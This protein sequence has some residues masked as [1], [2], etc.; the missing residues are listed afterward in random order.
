MPRKVRSGEHR[1]QYC[2]NPD[3]GIRS[4]PHVAIVD[5]EGHVRW[6][7]VG[8]KAIEDRV[9]ELLMAMGVKPP[10]RATV[11]LATAIV[12]SGDP[13]AERVR[14]P[15]DP[16]AM[17]RFTLYHGP[18]ITLGSL[19]TQPSNSLINQSFHAKER[20]EPLNGD[21]FGIAWYAPEHSEPAVFR[22]ITP[23]WNNTNLQSLARVVKSK[24]ILAH[25]RAATQVSASSEANCHPFTH[26]PYAFM[27]NGDIGGFGRVRRP[28]LSQLSDRS[29][30]AIK[31]TTD[32][33]HAFALFLDEAGTGEL[34]AK[35]M[36]E[37]LRRTVVRIVT[38]AL[39]HGEAEPSYLNFAV[40]N[41]AVSAVTR[42]SN[43]PDH[44]GESLHL[45]RGRR[46]VC[47]GSVCRMVE[48]DGPSTA[49][50]VSS[51]P[52]SED[53][54]WEAVPANHVVTIDDRHRVKIMPV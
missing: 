24:V 54:G 46:Y 25:V 53:A 28:L 11:P 30:D 17:C 15:I 38:L 39:Q 4:I 10:A 5:A 29:F 32:S 45:N 31:G 8:G 47:E 26:G 21:G 14:Q 3:F 18:A 13:Q 12:E 44:G 51:E 22:A 49:V 1:K 43:A 35:G 37:A 36:A 2:F 34:D 20:E 52:L 9:D 27:H 42:F 23:A 50:V 19:V 33:E 6:N 41:G 16:P 40:S 48:P 7:D